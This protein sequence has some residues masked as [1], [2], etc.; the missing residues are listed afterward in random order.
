MTAAAIFGEL[1]AAWLFGFSALISIINPPAGALI[2]HGMTRW[3]TEQERARLARSIAINSFIVLL[4][5]LFLGTPI[6]GFFGISLEALRIAGGLTVDGRL[7]NAER[8]RR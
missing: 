1:F 8:G 3:L 7:A 6:L 5:A 2:F 4:A